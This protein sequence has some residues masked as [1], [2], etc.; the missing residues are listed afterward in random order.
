MTGFDATENDKM[1]DFF[2]S[3][4]FLV[5][6]FSFHSNKTKIRR[7][8]RKKKEKKTESLTVARKDLMEKVVIVRTS[9]N[10]KKL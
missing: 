7:M 5:N 4:E 8:E 3:V 10:F 2:F 6:R 9:K 1:K